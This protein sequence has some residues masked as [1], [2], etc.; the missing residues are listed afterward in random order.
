MLA[1]ARETQQR[2]RRA[3]IGAVLRTSLVFWGLNWMA[4]YTLLQVW[5]G[6]PA[7]ALWG[8]ASFSLAVFSRRHATEAALVV[9]GWEARFQRAWWVILGGSIACAIVVAPAPFATYLL[10]S[11]AVW[12]IAYTLYGVVAGDREIAALGGVV[13]ALAA[14]THAFAPADALAVF[15]LT[16]GGG[17]ALLGLLRWRRGP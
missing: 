9:S 7:L 5:P 12:G 14:V 17:M 6:W 8:V 13:I 4:G 1:S 10:L 2:G 16:A 11:G 3:A 15:G